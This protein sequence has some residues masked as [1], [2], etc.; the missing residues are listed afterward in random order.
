MAVHNGDIQRVF[1]PSTGY[2]ISAHPMAQ[3]GAS[4]IEPCGS[5]V[6][7]TTTTTINTVA[8]VVVV[9]VIFYSLE[10]GIATVCMWRSKDNCRNR[11]SL[12]TI[13]V[14]AR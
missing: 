6:H 8:I 13:R 2:F 10:G 4:E 9:V 12:T 3:N 1:P 14:L 5:K 11:F 7:L